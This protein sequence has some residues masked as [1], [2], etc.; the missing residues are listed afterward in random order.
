MDASFD[1]E[2]STLRLVAATA[3]DTRAL[4]HAR[5]VSEFRKQ[6][7]GEGPGPTEADLQSL[8]RLVLVETALLQQLDVAVRLQSAPSDGAHDRH[9]RGDARSL[10][11]WPDAHP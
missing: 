2:V 4:A 8:A 1:A 7:Q 6:L 5:I 9:A 3:S 10:P 11:R